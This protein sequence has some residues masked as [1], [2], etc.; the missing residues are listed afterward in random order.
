VH[1]V[2]C[3]IY[4][5]R[6]P[7]KD[8]HGKKGN[9]QWEKGLIGIRPEKKKEETRGKISKVWVGKREKRKGQKIWTEELGGWSGFWT[10][11]KGGLPG[12]RVQKGKAIKSLI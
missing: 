1:N 6:E 9:Q 11:E 7:G 12:L 5:I 2:L 4:N 10:S 3:S 8:R